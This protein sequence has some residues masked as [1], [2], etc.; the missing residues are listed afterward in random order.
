M[1]ARTWI[2]FLDFWKYSYI[3]EI[4]LPRK[5]TQKY[6]RNLLDLLVVTNYIRFVWSLGKNEIVNQKNIDTIN[7]ENK[8]SYLQ[9][10]KQNLS[11]KCSTRRSNWEK[12]YKSAKLSYISCSLAHFSGYCRK[13]KEF[14]AAGRS[15]Q[16]TYK[17]TISERS[18][19]NCSWKDFRY[20]SISSHFAAVLEKKGILSSHI[21]KFESYRSRS[22]ITH[23]R[24]AGGEGRKGG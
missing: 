2:I 23:P 24:K 4:V 7:S 16:E 6:R 14:S 1:H 12:C 17:T 9:P 21:P 3:P 18:S 19:V 13:K 11:M 5:N 10:A 8:K 15:T 20:F 22:P